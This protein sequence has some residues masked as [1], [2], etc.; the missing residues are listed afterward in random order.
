[1]VERG[2]ELVFELDLYFNHSEAFP[3]GRSGGG[4]WGKLFDRNGTV[5]TDTCLMRTEHP[6]PTSSSPLILCFK[7]PFLSLGLVFQ[8]T[9]E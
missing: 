5:N 1:M 2:D 8:R 9:S 6:M 7:S 4:R 3:F